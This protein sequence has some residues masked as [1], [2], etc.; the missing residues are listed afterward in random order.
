MEFQRDIGNYFVLKGWSYWGELSILARLVEEV[1][2]FSTAVSHHHGEKQ[3]RAGEP[4]PSEEEE[5]G[6]ILFTLACCAN[7][8]GIDLEDCAIMSLKKVGI[9]D[10]DRWT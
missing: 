8:R 5:I 2:E 10:A 3:V 4:E 9:R 1:G 7:K 6:D